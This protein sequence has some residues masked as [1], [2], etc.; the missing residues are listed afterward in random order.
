VQLSPG[1]PSSSLSFCP[2]GQEG[3]DRTRFLQGQEAMGS[4]VHR[5]IYL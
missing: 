1:P 5:A 3:I 2:Q 4:Y